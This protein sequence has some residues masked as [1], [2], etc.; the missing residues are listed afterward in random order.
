[1]QKTPKSGVQIEVHQGL[2]R[3]K[4]KV[5]GQLGVQLHKS[6]SWRTKLKIGKN[7]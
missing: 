7:P 5:Y 2:N 4:L 6:V 1:M 3:I